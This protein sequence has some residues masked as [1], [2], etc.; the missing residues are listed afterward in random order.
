MDLSLPYLFAL[1]AFVT[2]IGSFA[3]RY[4]SNLFDLSRFA[5]SLF[6]AA[7]RQLTVDYSLTPG[8]H[9]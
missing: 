6:F 5:T 9:Q 3:T 2:F 1:G 7:A 8:I 4:F